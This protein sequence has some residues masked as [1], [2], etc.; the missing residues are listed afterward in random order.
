MLFEMTAIVIGYMLGS[1]PSAY[2]VAKLR[3]GVD[4]REVGVGNMGAAN[5]FR[6]VGPWEGAVVWAIDVAKG[7]AAILVAQALNVPELWL[8]GAGFATLLGHSFPIYIGFRGGKGAATIM[9]IFLVLAPEA[10]SITFVLLAVP[11][12]FTRRIFYAICIVSPLLPLL[13]WRLES[14]ALLAFY[15]LALLFFVGLRNLPSSQ[16]LGTVLVRI[17]NRNA[18]EQSDEDN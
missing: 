12:Y 7:A 2:V 17:R 13:I 8:L 9:G 15:S 3:K 1:F 10:M 5:T 4:I 16:R 18:I 6:E 11:F 14:S